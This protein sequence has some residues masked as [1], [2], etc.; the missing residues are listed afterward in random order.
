MRSILLTLLV[1]LVFGII[2]LIGY[3]FVAKIILFAIHH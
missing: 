2:S 3:Y 1:M